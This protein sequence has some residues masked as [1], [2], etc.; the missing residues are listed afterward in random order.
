MSGLV[1]FVYRNV[2]KVTTEVEM[3]EFW[4]ARGIRVCF[5]NNETRDEE[6]DMALI[7]STAKKSA[8]FTRC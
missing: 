1:L 5:T 7:P 8:S 2:L 4:F 3:Q 6:K